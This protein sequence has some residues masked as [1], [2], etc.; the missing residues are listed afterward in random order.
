MSGTKR[1]VV[2]TGLGLVSPLGL[3]VK[4]NWINILD[5]K[6]AISAL[7]S[8]GNEKKLQLYHPNSFT[9]FFK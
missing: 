3:T 7:T 2:V 4:E 9:F 1:R 6:S 5:G 8:E